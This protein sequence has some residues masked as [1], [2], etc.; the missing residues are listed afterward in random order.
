MCHAGGWIS[1][2]AI[3]TSK[4]SVQIVC[5]QQRSGAQKVDK[6]QN[7]LTNYTKVARYE[8]FLTS[9]GKTVDVIFA[10]NTNECVLLIL[11]KLMKY[12]YLCELYFFQEGCRVYLLCAGYS[13]STCTL[14]SITRLDWSNLH[15]EEPPSRPGLLPM[16]FMTALLLQSGEHLGMGE[17]QLLGE[18]G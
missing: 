3:G 2:A 12:F 18:T 5:Y 9:M 16:P 14:I 17:G 6:L 11:Q 1:N 7:I 13:P 4:W 15:G 10:P 8:V